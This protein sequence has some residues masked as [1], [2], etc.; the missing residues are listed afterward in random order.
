MQ[1]LFCSNKQ[2]K[3]IIEGLKLLRLQ[4]KKSP[5]YRKYLLQSSTIWKENLLLVSE[6][7]KY[8]GELFYQ[9]CISQI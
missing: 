2:K 5:L 3:G 7:L 1:Q 6:A 9:I 8:I 4:R